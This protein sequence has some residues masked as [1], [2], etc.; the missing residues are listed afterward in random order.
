MT[1]LLGVTDM[2]AGLIAALGIVAVAGLSGCD[3]LGLGQKS[4]Q[5]PAPQPCHCVAAPAPVEHLAR[6][7]PTVMHHRHHRRYAENP[8]S[9][10]QDWAGAYQE[11]SPS[12]ESESREYDEG[13]ERVSH[14]DV[15]VD[16]YGRE[17]GYSHVT[18]VADARERLD[19]WHAYKSRCGD[20][21]RE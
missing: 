10:S 12:Y 2:R 8:H 15:W 14:E 9:Y 19:P 13:E 18:R 6:L 20:R 17:H 16:G 5:A 11:Q 7:A 21:E 4:A 1:G 3:E